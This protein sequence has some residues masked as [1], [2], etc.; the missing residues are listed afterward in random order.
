LLCRNDSRGSIGDND[1]D[2]EL[3]E[4]GRQFGKALAASPAPTM[5]D[6]DITTFDPTEFAQPLHKGSD[7][8]ALGRVRGRAQVTDDGLRS[9]L[10]RV[11]RERPCSHRAAE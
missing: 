1:V 3:N 10:L 9:W 2:F 5:F 8:S 11:R 4:L 6:R 7:P